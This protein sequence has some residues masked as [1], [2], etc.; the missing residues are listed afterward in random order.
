MFAM[1]LLHRSIR[2]QK[3]HV[4]ACIVQHR[5]LTGAEAVNALRPF[6]FAVHPDFFGQ[7]PREREIN[8][9]SLKRFNGYLENLERPGSHFP[10]PM[11]LTFYV[12]EIKQSSMEQ[13]QLLTSG[14]RFVSFTLSTKD[15]L[16]TVMNVLTSCSL[17][18]E[19]MK[20]L[21]ETPT[22]PLEAQR[23]FYRPIKWDKSYYSFTGFSDPEEE[24]QQ[25]RSVGP[26][27]SLWLSNNE[28]KAT[29]K[30]KVSL[31]RRDELNRLKTELFH[32]FHLEDIRLQVDEDAAVKQCVQRLSLRSLSKEPSI[33]SA[34]MV[35]C[36]KRLMEQHS[37]LLQG[38]HVHVSHFYSVMQDGD[39]C[40][41][42][43]WKG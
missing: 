31:P 20:A 42:W 21:S 7:Y 28:P 2:L 26:T 35:T 17:P 36:C 30:H 22:R 40:V 41:P 18:V 16:S 9:N 19:H 8:E 4:A 32:K 1:V 15:V 33:S 14:F 43:D 23:T 39:M 3:K 24:M 29:H 10:K 12:R 27:L 34:Q 11:K 13:Q 6:Y 37:P 5:A 25:A 38:L